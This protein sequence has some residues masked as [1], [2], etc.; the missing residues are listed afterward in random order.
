MERSW[1]SLQG[2]IMEAPKVDVTL[3]QVSSTQEAFG[4]IVLLLSVDLGLAVGYIC[5]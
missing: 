1:L 4:F 5:K 3:A 2:A